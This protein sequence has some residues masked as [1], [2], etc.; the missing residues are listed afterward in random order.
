MMDKNDNIFSTSGDPAEVL[1]QQLFHL[2]KY[3]TPDAVRLIRNRHNIMR[4]VREINSRKHRSLSDLLA[5]NLPWF[6]AEPRY[7]I[8]ALFIVFASLQF[9]GANTQKQ[10]RDN[11]D[12]YTRNNTM[13]VAA[14]ASTLYTNSIV[15]PE[16]PDDINFFP[17]QQT[18]SGIM[19]VGR[20]VDRP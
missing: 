17:E 7:G 11:S 20:K 9:W 5:V 2:K 14:P 12:F 18:D 19:F 6:F 4:Q 8:A 1:L 13:A 3:E 10:I 16:L 15:Y